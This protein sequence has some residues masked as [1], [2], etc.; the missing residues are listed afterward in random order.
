MSAL[1]PEGFVSHEWE[2]TGAFVVARRQSQLM[3]PV[4]YDGSVSSKVQDPLNW[5]PFGTPDPLFGSTMPHLE[6]SVAGFVG[7][8]FF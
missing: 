1:H 3:R 6:F 4:I 7:G 2:Q 5:F 8:G